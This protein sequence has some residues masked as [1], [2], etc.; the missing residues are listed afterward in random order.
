M[1]Q[2]ILPCLIILTLAVEM[3][4]AQE[5]NL[6]LHEANQ[7][8]TVVLYINDYTGSIQWE[9]SID[10]EIWIDVD[11]GSM[12][13]LRFIF[14][15]NTYF[16]AVV[17]VPGCDPFYSDVIYVQ[18][19][20][21]IDHD[22]DGF[23]EMQGDCDDTNPD[24]NPG[25]F[26]IC[27]D[28]IDQDCSGKDLHCDDYDND[29]DGFTENQ[30]DCDDTNAGIYPGASEICG[31]SIDQDCSGTDLDCNDEDNDGDGFTENQGDCD[32]TKAGIY[33][34]ASEICGDSIDQDCSGTDLDCND[35]DNDGD[36]FTENQGDCDDMNPDIHPN[37][38][39]I[40]GDGIDQDCSGTDENCPDVDDD[41]DGF[42][43]AQGD[44]DDTNPDIHP[45]ATEI[46]GDGIDQDCSGTDLNCE[47]VD[48][49][50][51][52]FTENQGDCDDS[53]ADINPN[54]AEIC[55]D[56]IDQDCSGTDLDCNS[57]DQ[58]G[59]GF[60]QN[61]GDCDDSN[62]AVFPGAVESNC[63][64]GVDQ[65]CNGV[66]CPIDT[67][68]LQTVCQ[69]EGF[70]CAPTYNA[71][72]KPQKIVLAT[73]EGQRHDWND[74]LNEVNIPL[75]LK[76]LDLIACIEESFEEV[77]TCFYD[78]GLRKLIRR[79]YVVEI[80]IRDANL[81][82][83]RFYKKFRGG[84]PGACGQTETFFSFQYTKYRYGSE[85]DY[86]DIETWLSGIIN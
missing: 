12:D 6:V 23:S 46:C 55:G 2:K 36:G 51:D 31:D 15:A 84:T 16:R 1:I 80:R 14:N 5:S 47:D 11:N 62:P 58:D 10:N 32:D 52:G 35:E 27:G 20:I 67:I 76:E 57:V 41:E 13:S 66:E 79:R 22:A 19:A 33:P 73:S 30:G 26:E 61:Q 74:E 53:D 38:L 25:A 34:G 8:D 24:M 68:I 9:K 42:T 86:T 3:I 69:N 64:D 29:G 75:E 17:T 40:C 63:C 21:S 44:C 39:D 70:S 59:D 60:S 7:N 50:G 49:D 43:E 45:G 72:K 48:H 56:S 4:F 37:A 83:G 71:G 18:D 81:G 78:N 54:A 82:I 77:E 28:G 85:V 65:D